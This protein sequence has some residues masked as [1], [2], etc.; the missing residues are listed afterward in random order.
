MIYH[1]AQ[2]VIL[3]L[4]CPSGGIIQT[5]KVHLRHDHEARTDVSLTFQV[6]KNYTFMSVQW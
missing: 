4:F 5:Q 3:Y 6:E 1:I 2:V